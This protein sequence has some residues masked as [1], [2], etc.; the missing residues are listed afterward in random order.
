MPWDLQISERRGAVIDERFNG[1]D[2]EAEYVVI[3]CGVG[4]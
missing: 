4:Y 1:G 3:I 2:A